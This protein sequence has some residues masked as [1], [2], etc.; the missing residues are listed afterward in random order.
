MDWA[1]WS[2]EGFGGG[3]PSRCPFVV[4]RIQND[5]G[6]IEI[7]PE[8]EITDRAV[9]R[10]RQEKAWKWH[11]IRRHYLGKLGYTELASRLHRPVDAIKQMIW[12]AESSVGR[13]IL[14]LERPVDYGMLARRED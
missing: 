14:L 7:T 10:V 3:Y 4:D 11:I 12:A 9:A 2:M 13:Y 6:Y 1:A 8:I 5:H